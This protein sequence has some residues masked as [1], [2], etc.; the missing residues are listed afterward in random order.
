MMII[1]RS[2]APVWECMPSGLCPDIL[3]YYSTVE[4]S[5][6]VQQGHGILY[7]IPGNLPSP[8]PRA[9]SAACVFNC[10]MV[11]LRPNIR[12]FIFPLM[13]QLPLSKT[14]N[15][16]HTPSPGTERSEHA[17]GHPLSAKDLIHKPREHALHGPCTLP[18][19]MARRRAG[20]IRRSH[21]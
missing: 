18:F 7:K 12:N 6:S 3:S 2:Q 20:T 19:R 15:M 17:V 5:G 4:A 21:A 1:P 9:R 16:W 11:V 10:R 13:S 8:A 14:P